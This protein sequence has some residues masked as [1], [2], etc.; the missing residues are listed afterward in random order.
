MDKLFQVVLITRFFCTVAV[1]DL[2]VTC[3]SWSCLIYFADLNK[4]FVP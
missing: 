1:T 4:T 3:D 2:I